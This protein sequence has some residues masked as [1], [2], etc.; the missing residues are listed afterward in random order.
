MYPKVFHP[1]VIGNGD[2]V[3]VNG[4]VTASSGDSTEGGVVVVYAD[5]M[6]GEVAGGIGNVFIG[7]GEKEKCEVDGFEME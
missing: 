2:D 7:I 5:A 4:T 1:T 6:G 3:I